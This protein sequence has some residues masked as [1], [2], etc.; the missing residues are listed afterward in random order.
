MVNFKMAQNYDNLT[1][2]FLENRENL[3]KMKDNFKLIIPWESALKYIKLIVQYI[4][5]H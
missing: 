3:Q 1:T 2:R 5:N 4:F